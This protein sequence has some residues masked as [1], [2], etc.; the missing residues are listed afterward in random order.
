MPDTVEEVIEETPNT[1]VEPQLAGDMENADVGLSDEGEEPGSGTSPQPEPAPE[2][3]APAGPVVSP[4][5]APRLTQEQ[6]NQYLLGE[7]QKYRQAYEQLAAYVQQI[8][9]AGQP[10]AGPYG[11]PQGAGVGSPEPGRND[12]AT[13]ALSADEIAEFSGYD[14]SDPKVRRWADAEAAKQRRME[15]LERY[16]T[17]NL[18]PVQAS[19]A[20]MQAAK[21]EEEKWAEFLQSRPPDEHAKLVELKPK[22]REIAYQRNLPHWLDAYGVYTV[23]T[24]GQLDA[25][26]VQQGVRQGYTAAVETGERNKLANVAAGN[27]PRRGTMAQPRA[28]NFAEAALLAGHSK[29]DLP[30]RGR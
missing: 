14:I 6:M 11:A 15:Q 22:L 16:V 18:A 5:E 26:S 28:R 17:Q 24:P 10:Q 4:A 23:A 29:D 25:R 2:P 8:Q 7:A 9:S 3:A 30:Q 21:I 13:P 27:T 12:A 1:S 20:Q 19:F